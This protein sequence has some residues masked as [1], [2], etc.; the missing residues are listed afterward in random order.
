MTITE[1][2]AY[3]KGLAEG[4]AIDESKP[5][6]KI[7]KALIDLVDD[8]ALEVADLQQDTADLADYIDE[9]DYDLGDLEEDYYGEYDED[10]DCDCD[11]GCDDCDCDCDFEELEALDGEV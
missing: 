4:L 3:I 11:C 5:E 10:F 8:I 2:A 1:K 9:I 6:N 7:I